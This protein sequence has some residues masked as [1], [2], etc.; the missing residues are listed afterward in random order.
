MVRRLVAVV[1]VALLAGAPAFAQLDPEPKQQYLWRVVISVKPHPLLTQDFRDRLKRD[2]L[3]ALQP[4]LGNLGTVEVIDLAD[5]AR[6]ATK[7]PLWQQF[8]EKGFTALDAPRDLTGAKT[9]F[10]KIEYRDGKVHMESRQYDGFTGLSSPVVRTQST[11]APELAGRTA[12]L[13][14]DRDFGLVGTVEAI[15]GKSDEAK[16][17]IRGSGL[18]PVKDLVQ[19]GDVFAVAAVRKTN[20]PAPP[21]VRTATGKII[22]PPPGSVPPPGLTST[23]RDFTLLK[24]TDVGADGTCRCT[25]LT[26]YQNAMPTTGGVIGYRAM[27]LGTVKAPVAVRLMS[28]EG[29]VYKTASAVNVRASDNGFVVAGA[30]DQKDVCKFHSQTAQFRS[31]RAL[32]GIACVTVALGPSQAKQFPVPILNDEPI[33]IPFDIDPAKEER[34]AFER[35][36]LAA[37]NAAADARLAQSVC[38]EAVADLIKKQKNAEALARAQSGFT[39]ADSADKTLSDELTRLKEQGKAVQKAESVDGILTKMGQNVALL[40]AYNEQLS[41]HLKSLEEIV[42]RENDP[43][44]A[45]REVQAQAINARIAL[46]LARGDVDEALAAYT[47]L[48]EL[49]PDDAE[50]KKRKNELAAEW[51]VKDE[52][53]QKARD[54]LLKTWPTIATIPDFDES[55]K[56]IRNAV[57]VCKKHGDKLTIR[58]LL[59]VFEGAVVK[60]NELVAPLDP[61]SE[62]DRKLAKTAE[63]VGK[64]MAALEQELRKFVEG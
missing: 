9:H 24:V 16:V 15:G 28:S 18:G 41:K 63:S 2:L 58:K 22:N 53:H 11:R 57:D 50:I 56:T 25:I 62:A 4:G 61:A 14:L 54:Y 20:R 19:T 32:S 39:A 49:V 55:L 29:T 46:L 35:S 5:L 36:V 51:K 47:Q 64:V 23:P 3:A 12:G 52:A 27:K 21:P 6:D 17:L 7:E 43:A 31:D 48:S 45:A 38:F 42:K 59:I 37:A 30:G 33:T 44:A 13:M 34:A 10:L 26:R 40:K 8:S 1:A 60:L